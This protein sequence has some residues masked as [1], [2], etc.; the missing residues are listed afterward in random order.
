MA[1]E[2]G[3]ILACAGLALTVGVFAG[4][5]SALLSCWLLASLGAELSLARD[6]ILVEWGPSTLLVLFWGAAGYIS[7]VIAERHLGV[8]G[9]LAVVVVLAGAIGALVVDVALSK[10]IGE[11]G[12]S[13]LLA[14]KGL[15]ALLWWALGAK[16]VYAG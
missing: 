11:H 16:R 1:A 14:L 12:F 13:D 2:R 8:T 9:T 5:V 10:V 4:G 3:V 6:G 7:A 15:C